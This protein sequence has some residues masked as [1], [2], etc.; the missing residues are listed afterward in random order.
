LKR[1]YNNIVIKDTVYLNI[2]ISKLS[3]FGLVH[4]VILSEGFFYD[5]TYPAVIPRSPIPAAKNL[6]EIDL[7]HN[8]DDT[9]ILGDYFFNS[10]GY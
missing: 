10:L 6:P 2:N 7:L 4:G 1:V 9:I 5:N 8:Q 3:F